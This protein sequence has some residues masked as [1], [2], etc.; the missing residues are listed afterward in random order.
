MSRSQVIF[1]TGA[2]SFIGSHVVQ[3]LLVAGYHVR[4]TAR[5][6]KVGLVKESFAK[7]KDRF[8]VISVVDLGEDQVPDVHWQGVY[9]LIHVASPAP[10]R[11]EPEG[12]FKAAVQG[13]LNMMRQ[14]EKAGVRRMVIT[15]S[16][17]AVRNSKGTFGHEDWNNLTK[18]SA[19]A[20]QND[21]SIY[22]ASKALA[23]KAVWEW[24]AEHP[25]V[26]VITLCPTLVL[27]PLSDVLSRLPSPD[28]KALVTDNV[29]L[30]LIIPDGTLPWNNF[31]VDIRDIA[32]AHVLSLESPPTSLVGRKRL[33][34]SSPH[35]IT[36]E[37]ALQYIE[38]MRPELKDRLNKN[39]PPPGTPDRLPTD[40][41]RIEEV[42]GMKKEDFH[43]VE[44]T[45]LDSLDSLMRLLDNWK[46]DGVEVA[47]PIRGL[48]FVKEHFH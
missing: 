11:E 36:W 47:I 21:L 10:G 3:E 48:K 42:I 38:E 45:L 37:W 22:A 26:E 32:K 43:T 27:G 2:S 13:S 23:E 25:H 14:A 5:G 29:I 46:K 15:S 44:E 20:S 1:V 33:V 7:Y 18:E 4:G 28:F 12:M 39:Q 16:V 30:N 40:F 24:A 8:E 9:G 41:N 31:Y 6:Y 17:S 34:I 19:I 35:G